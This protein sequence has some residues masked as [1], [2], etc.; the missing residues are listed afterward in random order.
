MA[1][2]PTQRETI[3]AGLRLIMSCTLLLFV[4]G[5]AQLLKGPAQYASLPETDV[6]DQSP[7]LSATPR[8]V[9]PSRAR[10]QEAGINPS[11]ALQQSIDERAKWKRLA[12]A[13]LTSHQSVLSA[14]DQKT[15]SLETQD[16]ASTNSLKNKKE[17]DN[18]A[19]GTSNDYDREATMNRLVKGGQDAARAIC[20]R[21]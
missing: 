16:P 18:P 1:C 11:A 20:N 2:D 5:C 21:C 19:A 4:S 10:R 3:L 6:S 7:S 15:P 12:P 8:R 13:D 9:E 17:T 14:R